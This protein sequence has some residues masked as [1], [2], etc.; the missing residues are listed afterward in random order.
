[1]SYSVMSSVQ[2]AQ[3]KTFDVKHGLGG[4]SPLVVMTNFQKCKHH[5]LTVTFLQN[6]FPS[7]NPHSMEIKNKK[8][9]VLFDY[10]SEEDCIR[11]RHYRVTTPVSGMNRAMK[12]LLYDKGVPDLGDMD[13]MTEFLTKSSYASVINELNGRLDELNFMCRRVREKRRA[14]VESILISLPGEKRRSDG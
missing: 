1:M 9:V 7:V 10:D 14:T 8:R 4:A 13:T 11:F 6:M 12:A 3:G 5:D 2:R